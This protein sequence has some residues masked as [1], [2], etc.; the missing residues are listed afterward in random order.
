MAELELGLLLD[1]H[2]LFVKRGCELKHG[3][4]LCLGQ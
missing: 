3:A 1:G 2:Q 4:Q